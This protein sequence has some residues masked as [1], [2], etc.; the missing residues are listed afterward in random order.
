MYKYKKE[1]LHQIFKQ[2]DEL[3]PD[4][5]IIIFKDIIEFNK[6]KKDNKI[7]E[8][9]SGTGKGSKGFINLGFTNITGVE[10]QYDLGV[11]L[12]NKFK[13]YDDFNIIISSFEEW[14]EDYNNYDM[15]FSSNSFHLIDR[16]YR[17]NKIYSN[18]NY[19]GILAL[20]WSAESSKYRDIDIEIRN[21]YRRIVPELIDLN[22]L[23]LKEHLEKI[24]REIISSKLFYNIE[25]NNYTWYKIYTSEE[26]I[27]YLNTFTSY[28]LLD[29]NIKKELYD[30]I[31]NIIEKY[32]GIIKKSYNGI[33]LLGRKT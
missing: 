4:Y 12:W 23:N 28:R 11:Y 16:R 10:I 27:K 9:G 8:I 18:L 5:P 14:E 29:I 7:L 3:S 17:Y 24:K 26:Y 30:E 15:I 33:L 19:N 20:L 13:R 22:L 32:G 6:L 21:I 31:L 25:I 2:Y 1:S